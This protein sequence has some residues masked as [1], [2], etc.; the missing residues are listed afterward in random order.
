[1]FL[2]G[3]IAESYPN[4]ATPAA[5]EAATATSQY[6]RAVNLGSASA[7][8]TNNPAVIAA[9]A[10][11]A[12]S[13]DRG[14]VVAA[15]YVAALDRFDTAL[16]TGDVAIPGQTAANV[17]AGLIIHGNTRRR[18]ALLAPAVG[19][20]VA[21]AKAAVT[22]FLG[23]TGSE[24]AGLAYPW[25]KVDDGVGGFRVIS[26]EGYLAACR[27]RA[28]R[29]E[30]PWR[31]AAGEI[32]VARTVLGVNRVLTEAEISDLNDHQVIP[33]AVIGG[34]VQPYGARSLSLDLRNF[35]LMTGRDVMNVVAVLGVA[36]L[37]P[38]VFGTVDGR[39]HFQHQLESELRAVLEPML[40]AGGLYERIAADGSLL[41]PG[42]VVDAG[43]AVNTV[44]VLARDEVIVD[45]ALRVSPTG[46]HIHLRLT[47]VAF[48]ANL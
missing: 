28:R 9:T 17:G 40:S 47:K 29:L 38:Y 1:V 36:R 33:I 34:R 23:T 31:A 35:R 6:V 11:S 41:S 37:R 12:G 5:A 3:I 22:P 25:I 20:T 43:P 10:L 14:S 8:P 2:D 24:G 7:A 16:G 32:A 44:D 18:A 15:T 30:G 26:P 46:E 19:Q 21:Q 4:L 45:V 13:D 39:G 42:Y 48:D 27:A